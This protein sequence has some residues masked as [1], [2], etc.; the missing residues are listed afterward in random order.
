MR[1]LVI[2]QLICISIISGHVHGQVLKVFDLAL[3]QL[4]PVEYKALD[5]IALES[6]NF[7]LLD[8][9]VNLK[10]TDHYNIDWF[11]K[12]NGKFVSTQNLV[13]VTRDTSIYFLIS[14]NEACTFFDSTHIQINTLA[15]NT[16]LFNQGGNIRIYPNPSVGK[17]SIYVQDLS[18]SIHI[19]LFDLSGNKIFVRKAEIP[20]YNYTLNLDLY[21]IQSGIYII[22]V[23]FG[24]MRNYQK[25]SLIK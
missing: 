2:F 12:Q 6:S 21:N 24:T 9:L 4:P 7:I 5:S 13:E 20:S 17:I 11:V 19:S 14:Y 25:I 8:T 23:A 1:R 22:E 3:S 15:L 16:E 18:G 10:G